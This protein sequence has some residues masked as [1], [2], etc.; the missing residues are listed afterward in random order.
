VLGLTFESQGLCWALGYDQPSLILAGTVSSFV[1]CCRTC[2]LALCQVDD[3]LVLGYP[4][5][6]SVYR[7]LCRSFTSEHFRAH[8]CHSGQVCLRK[9]AMHGNT[10][11]EVVRQNMLFGRVAH[12]GPGPKHTAAA[13]CSSQDRTATCSCGTATSGAVCLPVA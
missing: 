9:F 1:H 10:W 5:V 8:C 2:Q 4:A 11:V 3:L 6:S 13:L 7:L 12:P